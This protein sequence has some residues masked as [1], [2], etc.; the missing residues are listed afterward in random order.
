MG[1]ALRSCACVGR[2]VGLPWWVNDHRLAGALSGSLLSLHRPR[3]SVTMLTITDRRSFPTGFSYTFGADRFSEKC[4][5]LAFCG[6]TFRIVVHL[7]TASAAI[8]VRRSFI[9]IVPDA[10]DFHML[11]S[12]IRAVMQRIAEIFFSASKE[13]C[14]ADIRPSGRSFG[15]Q[16]FGPSMQLITVKLSAL[17]LAI[18]LFGVNAVAQQY[19]TKQSLYELAM[20]AKLNASTIGLAAGQLE[21]A[22]LRFAAEL[23]RVVDDGD[24]MRV[25]PIVTRGPFENVYDLIYVRGIDAAIIY[26]DVFE[27]F[28]K[29]RRIA[30]IENRI[31]FI[32]HLF[33]SE[34]HVFVRPEINSLQELAGKPVNFNTHGTA[35]AYSGPII[36]ERLGIEV[37]P[38]FE[39]HPVAMAEMVKSDKYAA[40]VFVS[41]RPLDPF[42]K[43]KWP[44]G[45]KFLPVPLTDKLEE[46]YLPA[47]TRSLGLSRSHCRGPEHTN[48]CRACSAC[49]LCLA[50]GK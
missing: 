48:N 10:P 41:S 5:G 21:G 14:F 29:D 38:H 33:P 23:A 49:R 25:L 32:T 13:K 16:H 46:Y 40:V 47:R 19:P 36:F 12:D 6:H 9:E 31:H 20:Y 45:F 42:V 8:A 35:A 24:K 30:R 37:K 7:W 22:P 34:V 15:Q 4:Y 3:H 2:R 39:P 43:R 44:A 27:H 18:S 11:Q 1:P 28:K 26:G 50:T 17:F